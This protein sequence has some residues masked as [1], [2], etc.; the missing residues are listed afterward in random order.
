MGAMAETTSQ[1]LGEASGT[2]QNPERL[3]TDTRRM[4]PTESTKQGTQGLTET[5]VTDIDSGSEL[6]PLNICC[7]C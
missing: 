2:Q 4:G 7:D 1:T 5:G 6:G 3:R